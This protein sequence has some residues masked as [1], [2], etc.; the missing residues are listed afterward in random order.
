M[1][2]LNE[3]KTTLLSACAAGK[4]SR[5]ET[6]LEFTASRK[7]KGFNKKK[8]EGITQR[9]EEALSAQGRSAVK[10]RDTE[11]A[12]VTKE[13]LAGD[14]KKLTDCMAGREGAFVKETTIIEDINIKPKEANQWVDDVAYKNVGLQEVLL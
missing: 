9:L 10:K 12:V 7:K 14:A 5:A 4:E 13:R 11:D 6:S 8:P 3:K 1:K 2:N